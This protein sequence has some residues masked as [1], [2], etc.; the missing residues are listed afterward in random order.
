MSDK[1]ERTLREKI[2]SPE[3]WLASIDENDRRVAKFRREIE[4][5]VQEYLAEQL[6][7]TK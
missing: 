3:E 6:R 2:E 4:I 7:L 5:A 1:Q